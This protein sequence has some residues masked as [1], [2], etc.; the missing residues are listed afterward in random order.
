M[1]HGWLPEP[2]E[3]LPARLL[4]EIAATRRERARCSPYAMVILTRNNPIRQQALSSMRIVCRFDA[5]DMISQKVCPSTTWLFSAVSAAFEMPVIFLRRRYMSSDFL[6]SSISGG[7]N[8]RQFS[9]AVRARSELVRLLTIL[10]RTKWKNNFVVGLN[11]RSLLAV[12]HGRSIRTNF[13]HSR[14]FD[15][16]QDSY[17]TPRLTVMSGVDSPFTVA[18]ISTSQLSHN[19]NDDHQQIWSSPPS[20]EISTPP[21]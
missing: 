12:H 20:L 2:C 18:D 9:L 5:Q 13:F 6:S 21:S 19:N 16:N 7:L 3:D 1:V 4:T 17:I 11:T 10:L 15:N 14:P 8:D